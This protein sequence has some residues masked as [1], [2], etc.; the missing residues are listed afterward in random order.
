MI[1]LHVMTLPPEQRR[2]LPA[3]VPEEGQGIRSILGSAADRAWVAKTDPELVRRAMA[4][5]GVDLSV[6]MGWPWRSAERL[7]ACNEFV[8]ETVTRYPE[9]FVGLVVVDPRAG[10]AA[11]RALERWL[12]TGL[13][14]GLKI[15]PEWQGFELDDLQLLAPFLECLRE[16]GKLLMVHVAHPYQRPAGDHPHQLH[17]LLDEYRD[18]SVVATHLGGL[19]GFYYLHEPFRERFTNLY[20][21]TAFATFP[22]IARAY[23]DILPR[24]RLLFGSDHPFLDQK[25]LLQRLEDMELDR[26]EYERVAFG[27]ARRLLEKCGYVNPKWNA[28]NEDGYELSG[29]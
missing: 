12:D 5:N 14:V 29:Q 26:E 8:A 18:L 24:G 1:D 3:S 28:L 21:D 20:F 16:R 27:G 25:D 9:N 22:A 4:Q 17:R 11:L 13:F 19:Y 7:H 6:I 15:K 2:L 10:I 23:L